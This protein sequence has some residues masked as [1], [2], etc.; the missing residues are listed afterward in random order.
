MRRFFKV[1]GKIRI[2]EF[3]FLIL[4]GIYFGSSV[5]GESKISSYPLS[6][7]VKGSIGV[8]SGTDLD[9]GV[10]GRIHLPTHKGFFNIEVKLDSI[11]PSSASKFLKESKNFKEYNPNFADDFL[12][13]L[14]L[15]ALK[16]MLASVLFSGFL[17]LLAFRRF[18]VMLLGMGVSFILFF[19]ILLL[20]Y[21]TF[22]SKAINKPTYYG[23]VAMAPKVIGSAEDISDNFS[24]YRDQMGRLVDNVSKLYS[25]TSRET[26]VDKGYIKILH[27]SD[28]HLNPAGFDFITRLKDEFKVNLIV[29]SGDISDHGSEI[30]D[31]YFESIPKLKLPYIFVRGNHDSVHS[32]K[33]IEGYSNVI[34]L[35]AGKSAKIEGITFAGVGDFRFTPDKAITL[36]GSEE[37][38]SRSFDI[39]KNFSGSDFIVIHDPY[40][41]ERMDGISRYILSGHTHVRSIKELKSSTLLVEGSTGGGGL[42]PFKKDGSVSKLEASILYFNLKS[43]RIEF[44]DEVSMD[45]YGSY[46]VSISRKK[47]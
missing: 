19:V 21:L 25:T 5:F 34:N 44:V 13:S 23:L 20:S 45:G 1:G 27:V 41:G 6:A 22:D 39:L 40:I 36:K 4:L 43:S 29:D 12:G 46:G 35:S 14:F 17:I 38:T 32:E 26:P 3:I 18:R 30:E 10:L 15:I 7:D 33:V 28:L 42:R 2:L 31:F 37:L 47:L 24:R 11:S 8:K 16:S 9:L